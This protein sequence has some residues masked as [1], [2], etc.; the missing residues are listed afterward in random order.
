M[1]QSLVWFQRNSQNPF[2]KFSKASIRAFT[3]CMLLILGSQFVAN[4]QTL[5]SGKITDRKSGAGVPGVNVVVKGTSKGTSTNQEGKFSLSAPSNAILVISSV[6]YKK[7]EVSAGNKTEINISLEEDISAL[8]EVVVVGYGSQK[9][10]DLTGSIVSI[11][12]EDFQKGNISTPDQ[13]ITG[14]MAGVQITTNGGMPGSGSQIRIRGG[15][16]LNASNDPLIVIDGL[17][18][19]NSTIDGASNPLAF[20]NPND[21]E[22]FTVLKDAS[23]TAIYGSRAS[24]GVILITTKK[25][26][27]GDDFRA[28]FSTQAS[29][30]VK[31]GKIDVLSGDEFRTLVNAKGNDAAKALLG[32]SNTDWQDAITRT[33]ISTDNNLSLSG[34]YKNLPYRFSAGYT[35]QNGI[36]KTSSMDRTS[37]SLGLSPTF[38][39]NHLKVDL[40]LKGSVT[41]NNFANDGAYGTAVSFDPTQPVYSSKEAYNGYF[42]WLDASGTPI[43]I[44]PRNPLGLLEMRTDKAKVKK[45]IGNI[46]FDYKFHFLPELRANLNLGYDFTSS[47]GQ[48]NIPAS[49]AIN[50]S[51]KG[52]DEYYTRKNNNSTLEFYLNYVKDLKS[53]DSRIDVMGGYSYQDFLSERFDQ[54]KDLLNTGSYLKNYFYKTQSTLVSFYGRLNYAFKNRYLLTF[55]LRQDGSSRFSPDNRWG[56][57]PSAGFAWKLSEEPFI[58]E[59]DVFSDLKVR[60]GY[61]ITGQQNISSSNYPYLGLYTPGL[62]TAGYQLGD[63]YYN[64]IRPEG[65]DA[66]LKWEQTAT[67][68]IGLDF[69]IKKAR[70][71][72][73]V[74]YYFKKTKDL[75]AE[76]DLP[77]GSNFSSRLLTNVGN[78]ENQ[79]VE[80]T[81]NTNLIARKDFSWDVSFNITRNSTKITNLTRNPDPNYAGLEVG[82]IAGG[83]GGNIQ[84]HTVDYAP[85]SF[86]VYKQVYDANG[87][88]L[89]G[90]YADLNG[91]GKITPDDRYRYK[92][93]AADYF[94]GFTSTFSYKKFNA[95]FTLR[96]NI[97]N[98]VYNNVFSS[99]GNYTGLY[100]STGFLSNLSKDINTTQFNLNQNKSDYY[101]ENASFLRMDN[102]TVGY[103]FGKITRQGATLRLNAT[104]QNVFVITKYRGLDPEIAGGIDNKLYPRART[105]S[106]GAVVGF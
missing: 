55:T 31:Q 8:G 101:V 42:E 26:K 49:S 76:V 34:S 91:D 99:N 24:N 56:T 58:K 43:T 29:A 95:G 74:D 39:N 17:P 45:S 66:N 38:L 47:E 52:L 19:D 46:V 7:Q 40:N 18:I 64:T 32:K 37:L 12:S 83:T 96:G 68:N 14:K 72:G 21:I 25:G 87:K 103:N 59:S 20:V 57:F 71:S 75:L 16:S 69:A 84:I 97:G 61:G 94:Y 105:I 30:S 22:T 50:F 27:K 28:T 41:N 53:I 15:S 78:M 6:G 13:L 51:S 82:G 44:A 80:L 106:L 11:N 23:A 1:K 81:I 77:T 67:S 36:I 73:S 10:K 88:P 2:V 63:N 3:F 85:N 62:P 60:L 33:A 104:A 90:V 98:Y 100:N 65:Y 54:N 86:F 9:K 79:G 4:A 93:P 70:I 35:D 48:R 102:F 92:K 89:E 5:I